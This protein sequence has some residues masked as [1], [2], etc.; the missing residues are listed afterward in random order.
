[1]RCATSDTAGASASEATGVDCSSSST[2]AELERGRAGVDDQDVAQN[3]HVQSRTSGR[4][5]PCSRVYAR[6]AS[7]RSSICWRRCAARSAETGHAVDH[8]DHEVEAVEI[9]EHHHV[10]RRRRRPLFLVPANVQVARVR[11]PV[12]QPVDQ[13]RVAV[14]GEDD[15]PVAREQRVEVRVAQPVRVLA[16]RAAAAS[17]RP[18]SRREPSGR[19]DARA[20]APPPRASPA[21]GRRRSTRARRPARRPRRWTPSPRCP[22][23]RVQWTI[24]SSIDR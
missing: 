19:A 6:A 13:P 7:R 10:E 24:A 2:S 20:E 4:S 14:V 18:R 5:S 15:R 21:S 12:G 11:A 17:G 3:G 16:Y 23:P 8:V 22:T 9:V 1:M